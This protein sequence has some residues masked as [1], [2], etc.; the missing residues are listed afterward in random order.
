[1]PA[2]EV[3]ASDSRPSLQC[4]RRLVTFV[5]HSAAR[6]FAGAVPHW[7]ADVFCMPSIETYGLAIL[8]AMSSGCVPLVADFNGPGEIVQPGTGLKVPLET[9]EQIHRRNMPNEIVQLVE[10]ARVERRLL[11]EAARAHVVRFHDWKRIESSLA[12][13]IYDE[14]FFSKK[15][16]TAAGGDLPQ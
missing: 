9:P 5:D 10:D 4:D 11:G 12:G 16:S 13:R 8:E 15:S 2:I 1:M 7:K 6:G 14:G 3:I